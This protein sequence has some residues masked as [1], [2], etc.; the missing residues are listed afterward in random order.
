[1]EEMARLLNF[2]PSD[3]ILL[4]TDAPYLSPVPLRGKINTPLNIP[5]TYKFIA[6]QRGIVVEELCSIVDENISNLFALPA[7]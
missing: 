4:E 6:E 2:V 5:L 7:R 1:M 3:R